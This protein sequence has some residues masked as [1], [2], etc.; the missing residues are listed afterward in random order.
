MFVVICCEA[1]VGKWMLRFFK[2]KEKESFIMRKNANIMNWKFIRCS[3]DFR[4]KKHLLMESAQNYAEFAQIDLE[5]IS[6]VFRRSYGTSCVCKENT[7]D[8]LLVQR[9]WQTG[10]SF[11]EGEI[12]FVNVFFFSCRERSQN[13]GKTQSRDSRNWKWKNLKITF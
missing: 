1:N 3:F 10:C 6:W 2:E 12:D 4:F 5:P 13:D 9:I 11:F 8:D 7:F